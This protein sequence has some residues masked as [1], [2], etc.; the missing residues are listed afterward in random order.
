MHILGVNTTGVDPRE[1]R[2][3]GTGGWGRGA[4]SLRA[5]PGAER[6]R[7]GWSAGNQPAG[8]VLMDHPRRTREDREPDVGIVSRLR[9]FGRFF[10][11]PG[12]R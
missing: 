3:R 6:A 7:G 1:G 2:L 5:P 8:T 10:L 11:S 12:G 4:G 9:R